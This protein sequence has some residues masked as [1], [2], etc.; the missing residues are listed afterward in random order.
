MN[1]PRTTGQ[2]GPAR[3]KRVGMAVYGDISYDSRVRREAAA[4]AAAG[5]LVT[6]VCLGD[7][8]GPSE[9]PEAVSVV[10]LIP[11]STSVLPG[12]RAAH[13]KSRGGRIGGLLRRLAWLRGY[14]ANLRAWGRDV[15]A[16]CAD[17]DIWHLHDL[18]TLVAVMP[19]LRGPVPVVFDA[20]ELFLEAGTAASLPGPIKRLLAKY[21]RRL[22]RRASAIITVNEEVAVVLRRRYGR[23]SVDVVHNCPDRW[24]VPS[25]RP[26]RIRLA[27]GIPKDAPVILYHGVLTN[28][29]G[30]EALMDAILLPQLERAHLVLI[31]PG[32][33]RDHYVELAAMDQW[34]ARMHVLDPVPPADLLPWVA[35]ADVGAMPIQRSTINHYLSTPNKLFECLAAGTPVVASDFPAMRR[36]VDDPAGSVG[37]LC[38]PASVES[39]AGAIVTLLDMD[40][41]AI[42][43]LRHRCTTA[44]RERWNWQRESEVLVARYRELL[45]S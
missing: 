35:S 3:P 33:A 24:T 17:V 43:A 14:T 37:V 13:S 9:L 29:R 34:R 40:P 31:G 8:T 10:V 4:L 30:I 15:S 2:T 27:T 20:H 25:P 44:A 11:Q 42:R 6:L 19:R 22:A 45:G 21:E 41:D 32:A 26:D 18:T 36:V 39:V 12:T 16:A 7:R 38:D 23:D 1:Q 28:H 5:Y